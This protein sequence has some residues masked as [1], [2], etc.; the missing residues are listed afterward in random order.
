MPFYDYICNDCGHRFE[1]LQTMSDEPV[2]VCPTCGGAVRRVITGGAGFIVKGGTRA[3]RVSSPGGC[4]PGKGGKDCDKN[5]APC[6]GAEERC[7][8]GGCC[9]QE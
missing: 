4:S 8:S 9:S 2:K 1:R 6:C 7:S 5:E 3:C